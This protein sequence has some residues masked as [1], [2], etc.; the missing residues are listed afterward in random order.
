MID[1]R[2]EVGEW[3][4]LLLDGARQLVETP[5]AVKLLGMSELRG[6]QSAS[7]H[8]QR[9]IVGLQRHRKW[10]AVF[11]AVREGES[12]RIG[13]AAWALREQSPR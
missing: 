12:R 11:S 6:V 3:I 2:T 1:G 9:F 5:K 7:Q 13:K 10:M 8:R 4:M